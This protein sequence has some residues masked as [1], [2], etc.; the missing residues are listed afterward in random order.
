MKTERIGIASAGN[1]IVDRVKMV[2]RIPERGLLANILSESLSTGGA[3]S[4]V[5]MDLAR[6]KAPFPL[7]GIGIIGN[8]PEGDFVLKKCR[9]HHI[10]IHGLIRTH[11]ARTSY[12][13][14]MNEVETGVR[15][16]FHHRGANAS[17]SIEH[18]NVQGL[19]CR[20][21]HLG[22]LLLLDAIDAP[23][24]TEGTVAAAL[25]KEVKQAG[26]TTSVDVVSEDSDRF[27][28]I[29]PP[30]LKYTDFLIINEIEASR[31][32]GIPVRKRDQSLDGTAVTEAVEKIFALGSMRMVA[33]HMP[34]GVYVRESDGTRF[35]RG[36]LHLPQGFIKGTL[37]AGD[38]FCAGMLYGIHEQWPTEKAVDLGIAT[39]TACLADPSAT[40]GIPAM[41]EV[42]RLTSQ[43]NRDPAPVQMT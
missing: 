14:V 37:G 31:I 28:L 10:D 2:D 12:T 33:V 27:R 43:F 36:S 16:F 23:H 7:A 4:N 20:H 39:A 30:A 41:P 22:Y 17:F 24:P 11:Y 18:V 34:E 35:S 42:L 6:L 15:T 5:L 8:D 1:W 40:D 21:F 3:P 9:E 38:A 19:T 32:V 26:I 13:D 29:V 25:L